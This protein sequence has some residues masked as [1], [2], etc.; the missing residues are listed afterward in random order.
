MSTQNHI[1]KSNNYEHIQRKVK[2]MYI[3]DLHIHSR[4]SRATSKEGDPEH[5][6]L[7]ARKKGIHL[8]GTGDFT[9]PQWREELK[10]KLEPEGTGLYKL[11]KEYRIQDGETPD[12]IEP[13]FVV[14]G[15]IS[16][17]YKKN[18]KTRKVHNLLILP[19]LEAGDRLS[20][21]LEE[22]GNIHSDGRPILGLDSRDL[23]EIMLETVPNGIFVPAHIWTP[24]FAM[25]GAFSGFD[26]V[27]ECFED[28]TPYI[29]AVETG[30]SSDPPM[31]WRVSALDRYQLISNSDAH[32]PGK[33]G[34]EANLMD[35]ELSYEGLEKAIQTGEG[36]EGTIEFFPEEGKYHYDGHRKCHLCLSPAQTREY[37]GRCP[38][39]GRKLTIG[40]EHRVE[41]LAD[42]PAGFIK[43]GAKAFESLMPLPELIA[44]ATGHSAGS[45]GTERIYGEMLRTLGPEFEILR[46]V[47]VEDIKKQAGYF[48]G[49]GVQRLRE[50]QVERHPGFDG[51]YGTIKL[52]RGSELEDTQGQISLFDGF[53][54]ENTVQV[55]PEQKTLQMIPP[56]G[57]VS[58]N[59][60]EK[61]QEKE[62]L[63]ALN[64]KQREAVESIS[65]VTAVIA[66]PG[67]GKTKT[68]I[69][70]I[71]YLIER[72]KVKPSEITAVTFTNKAAQE[73]RSRL[74]KELGNKKALRQLQ[75]GTF[76]SICL[77]ILKEQGEKFSLADEIQVKELAQETI[78]TWNMK[79]SLKDFL[80]GISLYKSGPGERKLPDEIWEKAFNHYQELLKERNLADFDDLLLRAVSLARSDDQNEEY[81][82]RFTYLLVDE[83]QDVNPV[84]YDLMLEWAKGGRELFVIGDPDQAIYGFRGS[85][86]R[87]F[88]RLKED[89]PDTRMI[90]LEENY[91]SV[92]T[93]VDSA[94]AVISQNPGEQRY[95]KA[96][97]GGGEKLRIVEAA[98]DLSEG[99]F[100]AKEINRQTGGMDMVEVQKGFQSEAD[101]TQRSFSEIAVLCRAHRQFRIL[102]KCLAQEGIP[103]VTV[104][105]EDYLMDPAVRGTISFFKSL[106]EE[107]P[108][109]RSLALRLLWQLPE[110]EVADEIYQ[111]AKKKYLP[112]LKKG[113]PEKILKSWQEDMNLKEKPEMLKLCQTA[114]QYT[115]M[116]E[117]LRDLSL[118]EEG[119]LTRRP[120]KSYSA[121]A[122]TLMTLHGSKGLE[123]PL[124][125]LCGAQKD[126][127]P[128]EKSSYPAD[129]E[130]ERRLFFVGM[131]RA[132]DELILTYVR[133][134]SPFLEDIPEQFVLK[135][136]AGKKREEGRMEQMS[137]FDFIK[138]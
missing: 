94:V 44:Q 64:E 29:H 38:V 69:E 132:R 25:F 72:R 117:F 89:R 9:H 75:I 22:I 118:G 18:G 105:R 43:K 51:E 54:L 109:A 32:S 93:V 115:G 52:F 92:S 57:K 53:G 135:E 65:P 112:M 41:E 21:R 81:K 37:Q 48:I 30:L 110:T 79:I 90:C 34:R 82:K 113:K 129:P 108:Q 46:T 134:P 56:V 36:L 126:I 5:L 24:H 77:D 114:I 106:A 16:S 13:R 127:L 133:E 55:H 15:E 47:P 67:T 68:L 83:F 26:T 102:E 85:D 120:G 61:D 84:Q 74:E 87:C 2:T 11:K 39:C 17:I 10:E 63:P 31:N 19:G 59:M 122:V 128:L 80:S 1:I 98:S 7:W 104:G 40:V 111:K 130:E 107:D 28:L 58:R 86:S 27:E 123:F 42:R 3:S 45:A 99:I 103:Y 136:K 124:V 95:L 78:D 101:R 62:E 96:H 20:A 14:T 131:T 8:V 71:L 35:T 116:K 125:F 76:H 50:G 100:V 6:E 138:E 33:L 137:L 60:P 4:F 12:S 119:D 91:R 73:M 49:E 121:G 23:L 70:K 66:G 88:E 97:R